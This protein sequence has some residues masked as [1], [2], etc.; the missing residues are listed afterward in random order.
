MGKTLMN[1]MELQQAI[2]KYPEIPIVSICV[3]STADNA[4]EAIKLSAIDSLQKPLTPKKL[5]ILVHNVLES[6]LEYKSSLKSARKRDFDQA[7]ALDVSLL[8]AFAFLRQLENFRRF[9]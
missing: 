5:R 9:C 6:E 4:V 2:A 3:H 7:I 8:E 1:G